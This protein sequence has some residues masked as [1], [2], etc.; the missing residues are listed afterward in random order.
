M[1]AFAAAMSKVA[2]KVLERK[3]RAWPFTFFGAQQKSDISLEIRER[4]RTIPG[5]RS[6]RQI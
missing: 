2:E 5:K 3:K 6:D 4:D 1:F